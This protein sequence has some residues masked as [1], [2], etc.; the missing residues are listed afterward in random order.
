[1]SSNNGESIVIV[2]A[3]LCGTL[4]ALMLSE[5]GYKVTVYESRVEQTLFADSGRS[6]NITLTERGMRGLRL[7][8]GGLDQRI[9][10]SGIKCF[11]RRVHKHP[12]EQSNQACCGPAKGQFYTA[13]GT[14][15]DGN[16]FLLSIGRIALNKLLLKEL[17]TQKNITV[18]FGHKLKTVNLKAGALTFETVNEGNKVEARASMIIGTDGCW[19]TVRQQM[20]RQTAVQ[21]IDLLKM[22]PLKD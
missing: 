2:G 9:V 13:Y 6:F 19:S 1:M 20:M 22:P 21:W 17:I 18:H 15:L 7:L 8:K 12:S 5:K 14:N 3:G 4:A 10:A 16:D 11:G